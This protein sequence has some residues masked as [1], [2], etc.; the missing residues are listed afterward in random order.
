MIQILHR[1]PTWIAVEK[2]AGALVIPGRGEGDRAC[3]RDEISRQLQRRVWVVHRLDRDT[4]GILILALDAPTHRALSVAFEAGRIEKRYWALV[5]GPVSRPLDLD[6]ALVEGRRYRMRS[7]RAGE[8]GKPA[9]TLVR[10]IE[11]FRNAS[12]IEA[13]PIT[14]RTHQIRVHLAQAGHPLLT[15]RLYAREAVDGEPLISRTPLH[16]FKVSIR[17]IDGLSDQKIESPMPSDMEAALARL[18]TE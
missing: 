4:S 11:V 12:W 5:Q 18:R 2:P 8:R 9:R 13:Q 15:D 6:F 10:P 1:S 7:P 16:A 17:G 14:G 3:L